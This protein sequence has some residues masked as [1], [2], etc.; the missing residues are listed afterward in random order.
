M[1]TKLR[2]LV[3][4]AL[5]GGALLATQ[6]AMA[7]GFALQEQ[8]VSGLGNAYAG[9]AAVAEDASIVFFNAAGLTQLN[10]PSVVI[11][12]TAIDVNSKFN[13]TGSIAALA[14]P[15]GGAGGNTG[16]TTLLPAVYAAI[17]VN[18]WMTGGIGINAPFGL[19][20]E[21]DDDW[22]GRFQAIKSDVKTTNFNVALA[23][24]VHPK[25]SLGF[26][27]DYQT[28]DAELTSAIN[29]DAVV[30][31]AS[32]SPLAIGGILAA[33]PGLQG[34]SKVK[35]SDAAWG[36]DAGVLLTPTE[37]TNIGVSYRSALKYH[38]IG[39]ASFTAPTVTDP[40]VG[41]VIAGARATALANGPIT[42]DIKLPAS[43][44]AA[45]SQQVGRVELLGEV[46]WTEWSDIKEL[47]INRSNGA[48]LKNTPENWRNTWRYAIGANVKFNEAFKLRVGAAQDQS[49]VRDANRTPRLPDNDRTWFT[50]G[51]QIQAT[52]LLGFDLGYAYIKAKRADLNQSDG[53]TA[54][55][56]YPNGVLL[57][58]QKTKINIFGAQATVKF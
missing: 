16:G 31:Q 48:L 22:M 2:E 55:Q 28:I 54:A 42:L 13:D 51:A 7:A 47:R 3:F 44:R 24:K 38:I 10:K 45:I 4:G 11:S 46:Q 25:I 40:T 1:R 58:T 57:G 43:A 8:N 26:G 53:Y 17:P 29:Y 49:P 14:Q 34:S 19:K 56:G 9:S 37:T 36:F 15:K 39:D 41:A 23:F 32:L 33:N 21:Y 18:A 27:A 30:A 6:Y 12:A 20:T 5:S 52:P 50:A 35:G